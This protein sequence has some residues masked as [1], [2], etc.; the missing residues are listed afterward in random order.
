[1]FTPCKTNMEPENEPLEEEIPIK[2]HHVQVPFSGVY[3]FY[4]SWSSQFWPKI[5]VSCAF[6]FPWLFLKLN[7][8]CAAKNGSGSQARNGSIMP[9]RVPNKPA[10]LV[11][12]KVNHGSTSEGEAG[13]CTG[14]AKRGMSSFLFPSATQKGQISGGGDGRNP[15]F[16]SWYGKYPIIYRVLIHPRWLALGFLNHQP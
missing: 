1:M 11:A 5:V 4:P 8:F 13:S 7:S 15:A 12:L 3:H 14:T 6:F 10:K 2:N 16:T 9:I